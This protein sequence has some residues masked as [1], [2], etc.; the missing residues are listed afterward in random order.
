VD[1]E[2]VEAIKKWELPRTQTGVRSFLGFA[3]F[4]R[5]FIDDFAK[6]SAPLQR[7]TQKK[8]SGKRGIQLDREACEAFEK[9]KHLFISAPILALFDP[10]LKTVL[11]TDCSGWAM[12]GC[13]SQW[14]SQGRLRPVGYFSKKLSPCECNYDI[15]DKELLAIV[16]SVEFWRSELMSSR[17]KIEILT[18]HKNLQYFTSKRK[19][20][21]RQIRWK[22][23][24]DSLP[25]I[26][27]KYRPG[28]D[29]SRPDA[30]SRLEQNAPVDHNDPRLLNR[31]KQ[32]I[33]DNWL[34]VTEDVP[35]DQF[36]ISKNSNRTPFH[37]SDLNSLWNEG[38][39]ADGEFR[40]IRKA[41]QEDQRCFPPS[42]LSKISI[43][44]CS[45]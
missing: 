34:A 31:N 12:G 32:L 44:E 17:E 1:P 27:L 19:L 11:E 16:R 3:N 4:Y 45:I 26:T 30:L 10:E 21:E 40:D 2:K 38:V 13:L 23:L 6:L 9:L 24:L 29:S 25:G 36:H 20:S 42:V 37:E 39:Q 8:F 43:S 33:E 5:D 7:F 15:H 35:S 28:K 14:D 22:S 41:L 18:D